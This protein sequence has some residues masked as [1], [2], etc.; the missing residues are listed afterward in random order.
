LRRTWGR[1]TICVERNL[2]STYYC[3]EECMNA[4]WPKHKLYH[5]AQKERAKEIREG[6]V[7]EQ[8]HLVAGAPAAGRRCVRHGGGSRCEHPDSRTHSA[9]APSGGWGDTPAA[10]R[11]CIAHG[12]GSR[13][14]HPGAATA[15]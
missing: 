13:C 14:E 12:G 10:D 4:H 7:M 3:G 9:V 5:K 11:R 8:G 1:C 2:P 15:E 6:T